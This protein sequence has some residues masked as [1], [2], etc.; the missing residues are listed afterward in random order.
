MFFQGLREYGWIKGQNI[1]VERRYWENR[2]ERLPVLVNEFVHLKADIIV[3]SSGS[4][5]G[6]AR[7]VTNTIPIVILTSGDAVTQGLVASLA[8]PGGNVTGLTN[9]SPDTDR[10][11]LELLKEV[12]PKVSRV[13]VLRCS[14]DSPLNTVQWDE[15]QDGSPSTGSAAATCGGERSPRTLSTRC[16]RQLAS[17]PAHCSYTIAH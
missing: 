7:K 5:A 15:T 8:R 2:A 13:A 12:V 9:I 16:R 17:A 11:R 6:A 4:A 10:K 3:T 14:R 1:M